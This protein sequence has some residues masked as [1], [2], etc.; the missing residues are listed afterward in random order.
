VVGGW[1]LRNYSTVN[2]WDMAAIADIN[3]YC[4]SAVEVEANAEGISYDDGRSASDA[5]LS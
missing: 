2:P 5:R 1:Q 4:Y 3:L